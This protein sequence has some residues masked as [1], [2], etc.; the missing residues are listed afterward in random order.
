[1]KKMIKYVAWQ[2]NEIAYC[3]IKTNKELKEIGNQNL[4]KIYIKNINFFFNLIF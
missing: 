4:L 3:K 1:M 2:E